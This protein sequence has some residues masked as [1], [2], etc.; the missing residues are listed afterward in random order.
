LFEEI[1]DFDRI[2]FHGKITKLFFLEEGLP[3]F[4]LLLRVSF[5]QLSCEGLPLGLLLVIA[6][7]RG[8]VLS[9]V[10]LVSNEGLGACRDTA[11]GESGGDILLDIM[12]VESLA[13][14]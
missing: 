12:S 11:G 2:L 5:V 3:F 4:R 14:L 7:L 6:S 9:V 1:S 10:L 13:M 8:G